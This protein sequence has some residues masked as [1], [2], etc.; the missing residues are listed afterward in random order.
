[1]LLLYHVFSTVYFVSKNGLEKFPF[2]L[3]QGMIWSN[4]WIQVS[5]KIEFNW[6]PSRLF[7]SIPEGFSHVPAPADVLPASSVLLLHV[8][9]HL[10]QPL[11]L[12][13]PQ[14]PHRPQHC[15]HREQQEESKEV[16]LC[17]CQGT[18]CNVKQVFLT[19]GWSSVV[20][21]LWLLIEK[22]CRK[23]P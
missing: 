10:Q 16:Q 22:N 9:H 15:H 23:L 20:F 11:P 4:Q 8:H 7:G 12:Q 14:D 18:G 6:F 21:A 1:M 5:S 2:L 17:T 19:L 3:F 13:V